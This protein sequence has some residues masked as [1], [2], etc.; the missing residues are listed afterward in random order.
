LTELK[1]PYI[2]REQAEVS[3]LGSALIS[4]ECIGIIMAATHEDEFDGSYRTI[5]KAIRDVFNSGAPVDLTTVDNRLG[6]AYRHQLMEIMQLTPTA[7]NVNAYLQ[8]LREQSIVM[9]ANE[10][11]AQLMN[12]VDPDACRELIDKAGALLADRKR[13][14]RCTAEQLLT[15][16][17]NRMDQKPEYLDWGIERINESIYAEQGDFIVIGGRPSAGKTAFAIQCGTEMARKKRVGFFSLETEKY[18][19]ADRFVSYNASLSLKK[20]KKHAYS[21]DDYKTVNDHASE[22]CAN[23]MEFIHAAGATVSEI[24]SYA[25]AQRYEIIFVDYLQIVESGLKKALATEQVRT[26]SKDL[27]MLA[28]STGITVI[29]LAQLRRPETSSEG[30]KAPTM[31]DLKESGQIEQ[32]ADAIIFI[33]KTEPNLANSP[34][35]IKIGKNKEGT[36]GAFTMAFN[37][38]MQRFE[39]Q[40]K[41]S[42]KEDDSDEENPFQMP[43]DS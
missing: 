15:L 6:P 25:L 29:A 37:G 11:G 5:Y 18:K 7:A 24:R 16:F 17:Y 33:Y 10:I 30:E 22:I 41:T 1:T 39:E 4:P 19:F 23:K 14:E 38:D 12:E 42:L 9:R 21:E 13:F 28:Q 2:Q 31:A 20:I 3:V 26:I 43:I 27:H 40:S 35:K 34:R 36:L 32:D 8:V